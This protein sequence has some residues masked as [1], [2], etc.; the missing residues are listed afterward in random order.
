MYKCWL[1]FYLHVTVHRNKFIYNK[2]KYNAPIS[3]IYFGM[4]LYM[5]R[6]VPL[7]IV[8]SIFTV[9]SAM[10]YVI[11]VCRQLSSRTRI[12]PHPARKL[13]TNS[14]NICHWYVYSEFV[15]LVHLVCFIIKKFVT[16][17]SHMNVKKILLSF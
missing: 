1:F 6:T 14:C 13:S 15:K 11:Q 5:F 16:I 17:H 9:H 3:L 7:S 12:H 4:K 10:V 8:R 2:T